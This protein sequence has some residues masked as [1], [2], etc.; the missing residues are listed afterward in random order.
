MATELVIL[1]THPL[2]L[3]LSDAPGSGL[4]RRQA[5]RLSIMIGG[6]PASLVW[7]DF[8]ERF[9]KVNRVKIYQ[10]HKEIATIAQGTDTVSVYFIKLKELWADYDTMIIFPSCECPKSKDYVEHLRQQ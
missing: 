7:E 6:T 10:L 4:A 5:S 9:D 3:H 1:Y 8:Q 2:Y